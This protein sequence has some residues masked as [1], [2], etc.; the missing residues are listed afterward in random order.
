M[1]KLDR[2][3]IL[4]YYSLFTILC[5]ASYKLAAHNCF[6]FSKNFIK[7][8]KG[9]NFILVGYY[10]FKENVVLNGSNSLKSFFLACTTEYLLV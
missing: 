10:L 3:I 1:F 9:L 7:L 6:E 8:S 5:L 4:K 2:S